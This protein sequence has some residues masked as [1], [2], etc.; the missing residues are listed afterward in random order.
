MN[1][2]DK[3]K[4]LL[5]S[6]I[7]DLSSTKEDFVKN[8]GV[9]FT[10]D[11]KLPFDMVIKLVL[12]MKGNTLNKELYDF[13]GRNP[14][15]IVTSSA[16]IQQRDKLKENIFEEIFHRF[17]DSMEDLKTFKGYKL[18]AVDG[19][20]INIAYDENADTYIKPQ[21]TKK[22]GELSKGYNQYHLNAIYDLLN[23][24]Y[25]DAFLQPKPQ[26]DERRAF[27]TM[28]EKLEL[29]EKA[30]FIAD[31]GYPSWNLFSHF[32]YKDN[33]NYLIRVIDDGNTLVKD[34]PMK[35]FDIEKSIIV[36]TKQ[37]DRGKENHAIVKVLKGTQRNRKYKKEEKSPNTRYKQWDFGEKEELSIRIVRFKIT[38]TTYETIFT[39]LDRN[40]FSIEE[41]KTLY[42]MRWG[43]ETSF[44]ELKYIIG[45]TNLHSKKDE[46]VRQEIFA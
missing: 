4:S 25:I 37:S 7:D 36:S 6:I 45:L 3:I 13:F 9:D 27:I 44:R 42:G 14:N 18:Y 8:P 21:K 41:I 46:F 31:R 19:S 23:K 34:L 28:L 39:D 16:F 24:V 2:N 30:L 29:Q 5:D 12:S 38:E 43:I 1:Y 26:F 17:N 40:E 22:D 32:K 11:R 33:A 10:R 35:E 20:D 15:E